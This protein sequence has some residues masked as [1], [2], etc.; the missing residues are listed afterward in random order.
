MAFTTTGGALGPF[1]AGRI[2]DITGNY[3]S[4]LIICIILVTL[5]IILSLTLL[6]CKVRREG[7]LYSGG[8]DVI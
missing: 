2:F 5:A 3:S 8:S 4:A 7:S 6:R 1:I